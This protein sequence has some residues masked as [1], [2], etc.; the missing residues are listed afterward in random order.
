M[1]GLLRLWV[2]WDPPRGQSATFIWEHAARVPSDLGLLPLTLYRCI[3]LGSSHSSRLPHVRFSLNSAAAVVGWQPTST[4][5]GGGSA[6]SPSLGS[7]FSVCSTQSMGAHPYAPYSMT[8][9]TPQLEGLLH[10]SLAQFLAPT[11]HDFFL[12]IFMIYFIFILCSLV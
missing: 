8:L 12:N 3:F 2:G 4:V 7:E 5:Q 1:P 9:K 11:K 10:C 6:P